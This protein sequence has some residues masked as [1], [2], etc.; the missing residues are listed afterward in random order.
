MWSSE[1]QYLCWSHCLI[2][3][4]SCSSSHISAPTNLHWIFGFLRFGATQI[5]NQLESL[6]KF[7]VTS[8]IQSLGIIFERTLVVLLLFVIFLAQIGTSSHL[9]WT[10]ICPNKSTYFWRYFSQKSKRHSVLTLLGYERFPV[11]NFLFS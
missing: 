2:S 10:S 11:I 5:S 3:T 7:M 9:H 1:E 8:S 6:Y 4:I